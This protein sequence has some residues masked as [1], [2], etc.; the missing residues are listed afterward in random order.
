[1][2]THDLSFFKFYRCKCRKRKLFLL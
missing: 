2:I 1:L